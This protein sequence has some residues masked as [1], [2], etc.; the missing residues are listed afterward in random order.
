[1]ASFTAAVSGFRRDDDLRVEML[2][3]AERADG[4]GQRLELQRSLHPDEQDR[5]LRLDTYCIVRDG[6]ATHYGGVARWGL[7][8]A[9]LVVTLDR[10]A[11]A[12]LGTREFVIGIPPSEQD[13]IDAA[14]RTLLR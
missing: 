8:D 7:S 5:A 14:L 4:S 6:H 13:A 10:A 3:L 9:T 12:A 1:M 2:V 11:E